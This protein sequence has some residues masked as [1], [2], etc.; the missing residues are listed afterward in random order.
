MLSVNN[1][2][3]FILFSLLFFGSQNLFSK[4]T[5]GNPDLEHYIIV[6][7]KEPALPSEHLKI[8]ANQAFIEGV[9]NKIENDN[10]KILKIYSFVFVGF[11]VELNPSTVST[12][13]DNPDVR[14]IRKNDTVELFEDESP[15]ANWGLDRIDQE[16]LPLDNSYTPHFQGITSH[17]YIIDSGIRVSHKE[18]AGRIGEGFSA[19]GEE[20]PANEDCNGHGT[21][22]AGTVAGKTV[23]VANRSKIHS[24]RVFGCQGSTTYK[25]IL[26]AM[27]WVA[28]HHKK[29]AVVN[30]SLGGGFFEP[31]NLAVKNLTDS[32]VHVVVA[33]GNSN[34]DACTFSPASAPEAITVAASD[35]EDKLAGF[36]NWG[37]CVDIIAP[38]VHIT[39]A[40]SQS[41]SDYVAYSGTSM[42]SPHVAG[43]AAQLLQAYYKLSPEKLA[44]LLEKSANKGKIQNTKGSR[45]SLLYTSEIGTLP[46]VTTYEDKVIRFPK[47]RT[48]IKGF[49]RDPR[50]G[51]K[52]VKWS[53]ESGPGTLVPL[54]PP[55]A[56]RSNLYL[57]NLSVGIYTFRFE[58]LN[59][60]GYTN[61][62]TVRVIV[63]EGNLNPTPVF[64]ENQRIQSSAN[65]YL[66]ARKS[67]DLDGTIESSLWEF[68]S[69]PN[70]PNLI[71][72][73]TN[74]KTTVKDFIPGTYQFALTLTDN[75]GGVANKT[76]E[77][78][79]NSP[80]MLDQGKDQVLEWPMNSTSLTGSAYDLDG[81]INYTDSWQTA[82][83]SNATIVDRYSLTSE[84]KNLEIGTYTFALRARDDFG[85][86]TIKRVKIEVVDAIA[87]QGL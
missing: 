5:Q 67:Y 14:M 56:W 19:L 39:S 31:M 15:L 63:S 8:Q 4:S 27:E 76:A 37:S 47:K 1:Y 44:D 55:P 53:Q 87:D 83:P 58:A 32:G 70:Q 35:K 28:E 78:F 24:V 82:G 77:V 21:H 81:H 7:N 72:D 54:A 23:G 85:E 64:K 9:K 69:G 34:S 10:G 66:D 71:D 51:I 38:G 22:V 11:Y 2:S 33:A 16:N 30:M 26:D 45:N 18:F 3:I 25:I 46:Y 49:A 65:L 6:L 74:I 50:G 59:Y 40:S 80:P 84:I 41:D 68:V 60:R 62:D 48:V 57:N 43:V 17:S 52:S 36:S 12:L 86:F 61:S 13:L 75:E 79:V 42:A 73:G 20:D 29:P